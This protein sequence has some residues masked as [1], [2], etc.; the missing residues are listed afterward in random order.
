MMAEALASRC[1]PED[2]EVISACL[3]PHGVNPLA[4]RLLEEIDIDPD[5][6]PLLTPESIEL[7]TFDLVVTLG[8]FDPSCRPKLPGMPP[9]LHWDMPDPDS[10]VPE[11]IRLAELREAMQQIAN[12]MQGMMDSGLLHALYLTRNN[13]ELVLD[14]M[15]DGVMAH[16]SSRRIFYFNP[17][18]EAITGHRRDDVIGRD[19]H[20]VFPGRFCGGTCSYCEDGEDGTHVVRKER[21]F[22]RPDGEE[23][24]LDMVTMPLT[25]GNSR[26]VGALVSFKDNTELNKVRSRLRHHHKLFGL[27]GKD[28]EMVA[29]FE[30]LREVGP[31]QAPT[32]IQG[33]SG[34]GKELAALAIHSLSDRREASFVAVNCGALPEGVLESELFGHVRGAF[35]GAVKDKKGRFELADGG[36]LFLDEIGELS[37]AMQV[38]LLRVLQERNIEPVGAEKPRKVNVRIISAT[39]R[40]L[41]RQMER[42][43]FRRDLFY[44]LCVVPITMPPLRERRLDIPMLVEHFVEQIAE[45]SGRP[46][47][48]PGNDAIDLM[49]RYDWPGNVRELRNAIEYAYVKCYGDTIQVR[50]LPPEIREQKPSKQDKPPK[51]PKDDILKVLANTGGN[52]KEAAKRLR[53]GRA[54]LYRYLDFYDLS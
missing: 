40:D 39:N 23:R 52:K 36:S 47:L 22:T 53:I 33:E 45:E 26:N 42:K 9:H 2:V 30:Q 7:F 27:I 29:L 28:P 21:G 48:Q 49:T 13:L 24:M 46:L 6:M 20:D 18:A 44:R 32:L 51:V 34:T 5:A 4:R 43:H 54:T 35:T 17:A 8:R 31:S 14:N 25:D 19:C 10:T 38:K 50:H 16:T 1:C 3:A 41:R 15:L 11:K 37:P 12:R